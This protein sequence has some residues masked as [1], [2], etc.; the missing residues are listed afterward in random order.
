MIIFGIK[1][2]EE[3]SLDSILEVF[4]KTKDKLI[5]FVDVNTSKKENLEKELA[6]VSADIIKSNEVLG[7]ISKIIG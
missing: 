7:N 5:K 1:P 6:N 4:I 2:V 3:E